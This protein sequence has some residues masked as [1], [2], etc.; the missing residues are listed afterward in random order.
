MSNL[1]QAASLVV[2]NMADEAQTLANYDRLVEIVTDTYGKA[3]PDRCEKLL[4]LYEH[5]KD[6]LL[7]APASSKASYHNAYPGGY[8]AH[9]LHVHDI[10]LMMATVYKKNGGWVEFTKEELVFSALNHDLGK[11]GTEDGPYYTPQTSD[12]HRKTLGQLFQHNNEGQFLTVNDTTFFWLN[13]FG[14]TYSV[15][16]MLGIKLADGIYD[17]GN[18]KYLMNHE[19]FAMRSALPYIVHWADHMATVAE[20][21]VVLAELSQ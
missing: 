10:A 21:S 13:K 14:I 4:A 6:R 20:K 11:L 16:E 5:L 17:E 3:N 1:I 12:W 8:L 18:K 7:S 9:V 2:Q 19:P 15:N